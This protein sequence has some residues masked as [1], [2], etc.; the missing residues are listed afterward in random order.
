MWL[1]CDVKIALSNKSSVIERPIEFDYRSFV[2][3]MFDWQNLIVSSITYPGLL[4][5]TKACVVND[6]HLRNKAFD[7]FKESQ[8][9]VHALLAF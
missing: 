2:N 1:S 5:L 6:C 7:L 9:L 4:V 3:R 8:A